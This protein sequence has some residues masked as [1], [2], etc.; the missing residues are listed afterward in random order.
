MKTL[1]TL[2]V[3]VTLTIG[4]NAKAGLYIDPY[5]G[6]MLSGDYK[7]AS[8][9]NDLSGTD[10]GLR[11]GWGML[12]LSFGV[13]YRMINHTIEASGGNTD[14][15]GNALGAYVGYEFPIMFRV[16]GE[17][18][19]SGSVSGGGSDADVTGGTVIGVGYTGLPFV[20]INYEMVNSTYEFTGGS[21]GDNSYSLLSLSFPFS[22]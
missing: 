1:K 12:G 20:S 21:E 13:D 22:F 14:I 3:L 15:E 17:Y 2:L 8:T 18:F 5:F 7:A 19:F 9:T 16:Y 11:V 4:L 10:M 6:T